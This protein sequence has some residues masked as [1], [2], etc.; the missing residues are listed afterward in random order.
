MAVVTRLACLRLVRANARRGAALT[1]GDD[2]EAIVTDIYGTRD[3]SE[4]GSATCLLTALRDH[5]ARHR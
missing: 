3:K 5:L 2:V 1:S 4:E